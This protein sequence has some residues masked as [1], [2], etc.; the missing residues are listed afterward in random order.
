MQLRKT[1]NTFHES[2]GVFLVDCNSVHAPAVQGAK[3]NARV[4]IRKEITTLSKL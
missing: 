1:K 4:E 2:Q 3:K